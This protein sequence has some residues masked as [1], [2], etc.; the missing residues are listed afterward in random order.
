MSDSLPRLLTIMGSG[1][2]APTMVKVHR[3]ILERLGPPPVPAVLLDTPFGFQENATEL[4]QRV[5]HYFAESLRAGIEVASSSQADLEGEARPLEATEDPFAAEHIVASVRGARYVFAGPGSPTYALRKWSNSVVPSLI[6]EKLSHGGAITF[7]SAAALTLGTR[8]VPVYEVYKVGEDPF[9]LEG[10]DVLSAAG[11]NA[12]VIPHYNNAEGGTHDTRY[13]YLGER[14]LSLLEPELP[15]GSFVLGVDEH[16][17]LLLDLDEGTGAVAG[18]G[19]VTV[20]AKGRSR[21]Y[22]TGESMK[23]DELLSVADELARGGGS[24]TAVGAPGTDEGSASSGPSTGGEALDGEPDGSISGEDRGSAYEGSPLLGVVRE[25]EASF[26]G[27]LQAR[28]VRAAVGS[29][30]ELES[31]I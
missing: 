17:A 12:A 19:V 30:L 1:E 14:R 7:S 23:I 22:A 18:N 13:C 3:S 10:M 29:I 25:Q 11:I 6:R 28:D 16:T 4:A 8:T 21:T 26:S 9:W 24:S 31:Q 2:T 15:E 27:A 5:V 20:R